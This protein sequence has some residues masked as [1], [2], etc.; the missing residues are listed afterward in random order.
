MHTET[1]SVR[2]NVL[3]LPKCAPR[4]TAEHGA[5]RMCTEHKTR[6]DLAPKK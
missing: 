5:D 2:R 3:V 1:A 6:I 4:E